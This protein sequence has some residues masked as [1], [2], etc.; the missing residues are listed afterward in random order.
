MAADYLNKIVINI[1]S[2]RTQF[3]PEVR[4]ASRIE[5]PGVLCDTFLP[6]MDL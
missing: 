3:A 6:E 4:A 1:N 2:Q 5:L